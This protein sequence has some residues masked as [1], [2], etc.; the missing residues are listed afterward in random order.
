[1]RFLLAFVVLAGIAPSRSGQDLPAPGFSLSPA[2]FPPTS[3][4]AASALLSSGGFVIFD[5]QTVTQHASDGSTLLVLGT[6]PTQVFPSFCVVDRLEHHVYIG[7]SST[8]GI[9][10]L[11]LGTTGVP[12]PIA[13]L[14][15]C[16]DAVTSDAYLFVSA[17]TCGFFCGNEVWRVDLVTLQ[18][19]L[20]AQVPGASGPLALGAGGELYYASVS[21]AF[22]PPS[23]HASV[24]RWSQAESEGTLPIGLAD[25]D[26][27][28][29]GFEGAARM[30]TG[31]GPCELFLAETNF[32]TGLNQIRQVR[33]SLS[34]SPILLVGRA[35]TALGNLVVLEGQGPAQLRAFQPETGQLL[36]TTTDFSS[37]PELFLLRTRRP[38]ATLD[39]PTPTTLRLELVGGPPGGFAR[40][41]YCPRSRLPTEEQAFYW[42]DEV[43]G[44]FRSSKGCPRPL[45]VFY[46]LER[47]SDAALPALFSL[48]PTGQITMSSADP[49]GAGSSLAFQL[50][51]FDATMKCVGTSNVVTL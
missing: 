44:H 10:R 32:A 9:Y 28:A 31:E 38:A 42:P 17:A 14:P 1:M 46:G 13:S 48:G 50:L 51:L 4:L 37:P 36:Y 6:L 20:L 43:F 35:F 49:G 3:S 5:G 11:A 8:G 39:Q 27:V 16:Y 41:L 12:D 23:G 19:M 2:P 26:L 40:V 30:A 47:R 34:E 33:R 7:E 18:S 24:W 25:A 22:P 15:F 21:D 45:P 29:A